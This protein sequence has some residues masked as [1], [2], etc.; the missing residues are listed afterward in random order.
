M[1][2]GVT[3]IFGWPFS[4]KLQNWKLTIRCCLVLYSRN[5]L[6][7]F[8]WGFPSA[9]E[10]TDRTVN[11]KGNKNSFIERYHYTTLTETNLFSKNFEMTV[12]NYI[13]NADS[14]QRSTN[15][16]FWVYCYRTFLAET[17]YPWLISIRHNEPTLFAETQHPHPVTHIIKL[18]I[19]VSFLV[20]S[21][22]LRIR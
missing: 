1:N 6:Y 8:Q 14:C 4:P 10:T 3:I 7:F 20:L 16:L 21:A 11:P 13:F 18:R 19:F 9:R 17:Y 15:E 12:L 2:I 5:Y 22:R